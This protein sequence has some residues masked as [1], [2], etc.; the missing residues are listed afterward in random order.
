MRNVKTCIAAKMLGISPQTL[1]EALIQGKVTFGFAVKR[2]GSNSY[3]FHISQEQI[4]IYT[5][6]KVE[7]FIC[8]EE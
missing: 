8:K 6:K 5:G 1:R 7:D 3:T 2:N 4:E